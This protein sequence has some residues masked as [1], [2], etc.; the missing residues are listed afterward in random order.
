MS[1]DLLSLVKESISSDAVNKISTSLGESPAGVQKAFDA[2]IP[3]LLSSMMSK[4]STGGG[5]TSLLA[6]FNAGGHDANIL[7]NFSSAATGSGA[8]ALIESGKKILDAVLGSKTAGV[9]DAIS[10]QA[11][12]R[13]SS[14]SSI[15]AMAAPLALGAISKA[16]PHGVSV[17]SLTE[18]FHSQKDSIMRA[19]PAGLGSLVGLGGS[20]AAAGSAAVNKAAAAVVPESKG[21]NFW[22]L[23]A[24]LGALII[25][26]L[27]W[28]FNQGSPVQK[29]VET[30]STAASTAAATA[31]SAAS[32]AWAALGELFKRKLPNGIELNIPKLGIENKLLDYI[33]D[34]SKTPDKE[35][36]FDFDRLLF[37]TDSAVLKPESQQQLDDIANILKAYPKVKIRL[38]GY[39]DNTGDKAHNLALSNDRAQSVMKELVAKGIDAARMTAKGYGEEHPVADNATEEGRAKNRRISLRVTEK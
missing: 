36:W 7:H 17:A 31:T 6:L 4:G 22:P 27:I 15:L 2:G 9:A 24:L 34:A 21:M 37:D 3:A 18:L 35:T 38:G 33:E 12:V 20:V 23:L 13:A 30:A 25:G 32:S 11:G 39:T 1:I 28:Y 19:L 10:S 5:L 29:A 26:G 8:S 14:A 16:S